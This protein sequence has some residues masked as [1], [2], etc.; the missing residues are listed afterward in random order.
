MSVY[1]TAHTSSTN[2]P[3]SKLPWLPGIIH[4]AIKPAWHVNHGDH[5][6]TKLTDL[7]LDRV[8]GEVWMVCWA[9]LLLTATVITV[10]LQAKKDEQWFLL[11]RV[12]TEVE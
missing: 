1:P 12:L 5:K 3:F 2:L 7:D 8:C 6:K 11:V 9:M 10:K 4:A